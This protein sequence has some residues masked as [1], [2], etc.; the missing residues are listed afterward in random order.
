MNLFLRLLAG[1]LL[2]D[3]VLQ[4]GR[5]AEMKRV[6][7]R[8]LLYHIGIILVSTAI[9]TIP[10]PN[11][12]VIVAL[13]GL[14]H[15]LI[16]SV[17][18]FLV[19]PLRRGHLFYFVVDQGVH[20]GSLLI[21]TAWQ[22][23]ELGLSARALLHPHST[24]ERVYLLFCA[25]VVLIFTVPVVE[26]LLILD[27]SREDRP[28]NPHVTPRMRLL[29]AIERTAAFALMQTPWAFLMP[30]LFLPHFLY[31]LLVRGKTDESVAVAIARP[32]LSFLSTC[33]IGWLV[34]IV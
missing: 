2:G 26:A 16:D 20:V 27:L 17:R 21:I 11:W 30:P 24:V 18:T 3:F 1:H 25:L 7:W 15:L 29:G 5:I 14:L 19:P 34:Q 9:F 22:Q 33:L 8:G 4:T 13:V 10:A 32:A 12:P 31:R 23:P 6:G 28:D